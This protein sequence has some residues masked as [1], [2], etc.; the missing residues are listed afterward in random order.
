MRTIHSQK[1]GHAL[2]IEVEAKLGDHKQCLK[3]HPSYPTL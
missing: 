3:H 1:M 2:Q